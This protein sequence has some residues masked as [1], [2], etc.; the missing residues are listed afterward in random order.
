MAFSELSGI[1]HCD[2]VIASRTNFSGISQYPPG[3]R[4][5]AACCILVTLNTYDMHATRIESGRRDILQMYIDRYKDNYPEII[6][7]LP[8]IE[9]FSQGAALFELNSR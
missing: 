7:S 9:E 6:A 4:G 1:S 5:S 2:T 3:T 8:P